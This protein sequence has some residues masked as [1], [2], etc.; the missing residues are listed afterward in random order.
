VNDP[1]PAPERQ[2]LELIEDYCNGTIADQDFALLELRLLQDPAARSLYLRYMNLDAALQECGDALIQRWDAGNPPAAPPRRAHPFRIAGVLV[3]AA[4]GVLLAVALGVFWLNREREQPAAVASLERINGTVHVTTAAGEVRPVSAGIQVEPGDTVRTEGAQ[5]SV[6]LVSPGGTRF[7]LAGTTSLT[8]S[9]SRRESITVHGGSLF[10]AVAPQP[11]GQALVVLT[12]QARAEVLGTVFSLRATDDETEV[13][14]TEGRIR[15]TRLSD[16]QTV[17][18]VSGRRAVSNAEGVLVF[19]D[20]PRAPEDWSVDFEHGLPEGWTSGTFIN[21]G[22]PPGSKG[23][24]R[25][26]RATRREG[27]F[28]QVVTAS[29]WNY[30]LFQVHEGSHLHFTFRMSRPDWLNVILS[31]RTTDGD[32]PVFTSNYLFDEFPWQRL[33]P[34]R[35]YTLSIPLAQFRRLSAGGS[36]PFEGEVPFQLLFSSTEPDR[37]LVIDRMWITRGGPGAVELRPAD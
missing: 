29:E 18:V 13:S 24:V 35:W 21:D 28:F 14:V 6:V 1:A 16:G 3:L 37:G 2:L 30:G 33:E 26:V 23:A 34:Q 15:L 20:I 32:P 19:E 12:P 7:S 31:A 36:K 8:F 9:E 17:E 27:V 22:L 5:S 10:A 25:A 11:P 4:A